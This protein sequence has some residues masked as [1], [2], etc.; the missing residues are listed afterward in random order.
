MR[1]L[2]AWY[3]CA[4]VLVSI[5]QIS[6]IK[7]SFKL[8][9]KFK[10]SSKT[11]L[12]GIKTD[13]IYLH[14]ILSAFLL[15][16]VDHFVNCAMTKNAIFWQKKPNFIIVVTSKIFLLLSLSIW[17]NIA[18]ATCVYSSILFVSNSPKISYLNQFDFTFEIFFF[19]TI[20]PLSTEHF[21]LKNEEGDQT[22]WKFMLKLKLFCSI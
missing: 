12:L 11:C 17:S 7:S 2:S 18:F 9:N 4:T 21:S 20:S 19:H 16:P 22:I 3:S 15:H 8:M 1:L 14:C 6:N 13:K 5:L 10:S